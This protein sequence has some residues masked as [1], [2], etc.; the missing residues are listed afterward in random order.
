MTAV[1]AYR[2]VFQCGAGSFQMS[3]ISTPAVPISQ[4][5]GR[6]PVCRASSSVIVRRSSMRER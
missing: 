3:Q 1:A 4:P 5:S 2:T 6:P